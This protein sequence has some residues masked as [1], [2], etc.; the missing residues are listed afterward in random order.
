MLTT[1]QLQIPSVVSFFC[2]RQLHFKASVIMHRMLA[3][4]FDDPQ[5]RLWNWNNLA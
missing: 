3:A 2:F 4:N 5:A 1:Q